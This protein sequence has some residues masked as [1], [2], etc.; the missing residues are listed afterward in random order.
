[1]HV[2]GSGNARRLE[3]QRWPTKM[4]YLV[5]VHIELSICHLTS[6]SVVSTEYHT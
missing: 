1:M 3:W 2:I 5:D 4:H 6:S